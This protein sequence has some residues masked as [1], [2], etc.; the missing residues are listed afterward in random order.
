MNSKVGGFTLR[1]PGRSNLVVWAG[2][3]RV[4]IFL[5]SLIASGL[6]FGDD[7]D[8]Q[9]NPFEGQFR[10]GWAM[11]PADPGPDRPPAGRS[12][13]DY[14]MTRPADGS[15]VYDIPFPFE[16]LLER[17]DRETQ[18]D[19][20]RYGIRTV[21]IPIGRGLHARAAAPDYFSFPTVIASV[22]APVSTE[23]EYSSL[24]LR[25]RLFLSYQPRAAVLEVISFNEDAGRFEFQIVRGYGPGLVPRVYYARRGL[26]L[27]CHQNGGPI[28]TA[29]IYQET[30][31]NAL[32][33]TRLHDMAG[34]DPH[35]TDLSAGMETAFAIA[36]SARR[37]ERVPAWQRLWREAC[38]ARGD[39]GPA[40]R[41]R[42]AA[43]RM[44]LQY[45]LSGLRSFDRDVAAVVMSEV[46]RRWP[47]GMMIAGSRIP[48]REPLEKPILRDATSDSL[49]PRAIAALTAY[50]D[51][52]TPRRAPRRFGH[53]APNARPSVSSRGLGR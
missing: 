1:R 51:P 38:D 48:D 43:Y 53:S 5:A 37:M 9:P 20:L 11:Q 25:D 39:G 34:D 41:C 12:L 14:L 49:E 13:F 10:S 28:F 44:G 7:A 19:R 40:L 47:D 42:A 32:I 16:A 8:P 33:A 15:R 29:P 30:D 50:L 45:R 27:S 21:R 2:K 52:L 26:C 31:V 24:Q 35:P 22:D 18:R 3:L 6:A 4:S 17:V 23:S 36:G 46:R